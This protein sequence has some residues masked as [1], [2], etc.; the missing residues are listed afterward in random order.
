MRKEPFEL[1]EGDRSYLEQLLRKGQM[2]V[3]QF[4]R[5]TGL[6]ELDRGKKITAIAETLGVSRSTVSGWAKRYCQE[7]LIALNDK[8]RSGRPIELDGVQRAKI[9]ALACS[10][11]PVG[12]QRWTLRLLADKAVELNLCDHVCHTQ[13]SQILKKTS[14]SRI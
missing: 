7:G 12:H 1:T 5:A 9:T 6:L 10:E 3:R 2:G 14:S 11:P 8:P 13:V 4:K